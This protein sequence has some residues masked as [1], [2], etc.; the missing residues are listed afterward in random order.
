VQNPEKSCIEPT[1]CQVLPWLKILLP[2]ADGN[3]SLAQ[4]AGRVAQICQQHY[5]QVTFAKRGT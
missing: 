3:A 4:L 1:F 2:S 5:W